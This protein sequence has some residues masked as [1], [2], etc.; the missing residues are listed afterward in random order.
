MCRYYCTPSE[1]PDQHDQ[2]ETAAECYLVAQC[3]QWE[4]NYKSSVNA[5]RHCEIL[6]IENPTSYAVEE[7]IRRSEIVRYTFNRYEAARE[8]LQGYQRWVTEKE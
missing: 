7:L 5:L 3:L 8:A 2:I 1:K 6:K 4:Q